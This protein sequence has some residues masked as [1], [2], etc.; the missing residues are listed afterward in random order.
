[1][2]VTREFDQC[3]IFGVGAIVAVAVGIIV[4]L[5]AGV[6]VAV[7]E[8]LAD[9]TQEVKI[10]TISKTAILT[11]IFIISYAIHENAQRI[12]D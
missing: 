6:E 1:L 7:G 10:I 3:Q 4:G 2:N 11:F 5:T 8:G 9:G 12:K